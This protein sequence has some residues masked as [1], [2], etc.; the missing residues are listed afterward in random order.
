MPAFCEADTIGD[1]V[2]SIS[3]KFSIIVVDD[4]SNDGTGEIAK[5]A[6]AIVI[7]NKM[8]LGYEGSLNVAFKAAMEREAN[9]ILTI[10]AD[11]EHDPNYVDVFQYLL[12]EKK[13]PLV[14][15]VRSHRARIAERFFGHF[16]KAV[17]GID[18]IFCGMKGYSSTLYKAHGCFDNYRC[19]GAELCL[20]AVRSGIPFHQINITGKQRLGP[21]RFGAGLASNI[22]LTRAA[23]RA[24]YFSTAEFKNE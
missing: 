11:G 6:G 5:K 17:Y 15:G 23:M 20:S 8:N 10:D 3:P 24:L 22:A 1:L 4:Y 14:L 13:I 2:S 21:S 16:F 18:D 12:E 7:K 9:S 19:A